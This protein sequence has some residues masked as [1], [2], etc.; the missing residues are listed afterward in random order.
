MDLDSTPIAPP[1]LSETIVVKP[2]NQNNIT[3]QNGNKQ[4]NFF[5][6]D[7]VRY[8]LPSQSFLQSNVRMTGR[9]LPIPS[10]SAAFHSFWNT[11]TC[12]DGLTN[13]HILDELQQYNTLVSQM[14]TT[15]K[16]DQL[17]NQRLM[18]EGFQPND[19]YTNNLYWQLKSGGTT[20]ANNNS[21]AGAPT[22]GINSS[23]VESKAVQI[24]TTLKTDLLS[25]DQF[26]PV[27]VLGGLNMQLQ[28]EDYRRTLEFTTGSLGT[29][30]NKGVCCGKYNLTDGVGCA[31]IGTVGD[32]FVDGNVYQLRVG[33]ATGAVCGYVIARATTS[34]GPLTSV[35][36]F[37]TSNSAVAPPTHST[38][39]LTIV[40][41]AGGTN[42]VVTMTANNIPLGNLLV[43]SLDAPYFVDVAVGD[44]TSCLG[45]ITSTNGLLFGNGTLRDPFRTLNPISNASSGLNGSVQAPTDNNPFVVG[46]YL[47]VAK[48]DGSDTA[49]LGYIT[50]F[51]KSDLD[52]TTSGTAMM[53]IYFQPDF[54]LV[55]G[56]GNN[57]AVSA[58]GGNKTGAAPGAY[59]FVAGYGLYIE[60]V[61]RINGL[62][63]AHITAVSYS[64][65]LISQAKL[66]IDFTISDLEYHV[67][68][69]DMDKRIDDNDM[70]L[71]RGS[72]YAFDLNSVTTSLNNVTNIVGP[73]NQAIALPN[74]KRGLGILSIPLNQDAQFSVDKK[75]LVGDPTGNDVGSG[76]QLQQGMTNYQYNL[77]TIIGRQPY[78]AVPVEKY[79]F[80]NPLIQ[81]GA[82]SE[83]IK[84]N[85]SF[86]FS[87]SCLQALGM[88]FAIGRALAR[89]G[90]FF[91]IMSAGSIQLLANYE[92]VSSG[93]KLFCH[94]IKH[95]R[96]INISGS[97]IMIEN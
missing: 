57:K 33:S 28:Q 95:L 41:P 54:A 17:N 10:P 9:G 16:T 79:S 23:V 91:D 52:N 89:P 70:A 38:G 90:Q 86:G 30:S 25:T 74:I 56:L 3:K 66:K 87:T 94:F 11:I 40:A 4:I 31:T 75:S 49:N 42:A 15:M 62:T 24:S 35:D 85:D 97:G 44:P 65:D 71:S 53:R 7:Y 29:A 73:T 48:T 34:P 76:I 47:K 93:N 12:R 78:R 43:G 46:D 8:F 69:V 2:D 72:G 19:S 32:G 61:H 18:F 68:R 55:T 22:T 27:N 64:P 21:V 58:L 77:G 82:V 5:I 26:V 36:W 20:W 14:Y 59:T 50:G 60:P 51:T 63:P 13:S 92:N 83:L 6:P 81:T 45:S 84:A 39:A 80:K 1:V 96:R 67:K 37:C 88:N